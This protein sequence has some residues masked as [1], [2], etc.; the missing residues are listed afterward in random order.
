MHRRGQ[1]LERG[2]QIADQPSIFTDKLSD[3]RSGPMHFRYMFGWETSHVLD[4]AS[5]LEDTGGLTQ[6]QRLGGGDY[7]KR[8]VS[9]GRVSHSPL[10]VIITV[11]CMIAQ[12]S[13]RVFCT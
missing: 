13:T 12:V 1:Q 3:T 11:H 5:A 8:W 7:C 9:G 6:D 4:F 2:G 10:W